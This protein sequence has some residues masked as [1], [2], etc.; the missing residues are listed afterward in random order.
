MRGRREYYVYVSTTDMLTTTSCFLGDHSGLAPEFRTS[1]SR[2]LIASKTCQFREFRE[3]I[4]QN[5][6]ENQ[7]ILKLEK[8]FLPSK[9]DILHTQEKEQANS[10]S[11]RGRYS[12]RKNLPRLRRTVS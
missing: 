10:G 3:K 11:V 7:K 5:S 6:K 12:L 1:K 4:E 2:G 9:P 8:L